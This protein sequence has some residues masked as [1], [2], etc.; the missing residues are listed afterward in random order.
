[1]LSTGLAGS[2]ILLIPTLVGVLIAALVA[3]LVMAARQALIICLVVISPLAFVAYLLP[4][5]EKYFDK[6]KDLFITML[7]MFP[8]FSTV[9]AGA[10]LAGLA[11]IQ[12]AGSSLNLIILG[13][14]VM[15]APVVV[16]PL[17]IKFSG[18]LIGKIASLVNNPKKG[19][20]DRT[21]N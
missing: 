17:L 15:V 6:W 9:F 18:S 12:N 14:A 7:V 5:T 16:T 8:A 1:M 3:I 21:R 13:M 20:I 19:A 2:L 10:Q 4:N 11:I